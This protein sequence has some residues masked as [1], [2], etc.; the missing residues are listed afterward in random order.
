M[1]T[2]QHPGTCTKRAREALI[3]PLPLTGVTLCIANAR[4][5]RA[6]LRLQPGA[7]RRVRD[8]ASDVLRVHILEAC[9][10]VT[11]T[12]KRLHSRNINHELLAIVRDNRAGLAGSDRL[13]A[14]LGI[15]VDNVA[16]AGPAQTRLAGA[17]DVHAHGIADA[18]KRVSDVCGCHDV[19]PGGRVNEAHA[20]LL[21]PELIR[22]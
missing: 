2:S 9:H 13:N 1:R 8:S 19:L 16:R 20:D 21:R 22:L 10:G 17:R 18:E 3:F 4:T 11:L 14:I 12:P 7:L 6:V 15:R 5:S